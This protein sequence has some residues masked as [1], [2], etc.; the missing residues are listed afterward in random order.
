MPSIL[1]QI[2]D[3]D[4]SCAV[5]EVSLGPCGSIEVVPINVPEDFVQE[6]TLPHHQPVVVVCRGVSA[7]HRGSYFS[8][9]LNV[10][11]GAYQ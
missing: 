5:D 1:L 10:I 6:F 8:E 11:L 4:V 2:E 9:T 7:R 3:Q